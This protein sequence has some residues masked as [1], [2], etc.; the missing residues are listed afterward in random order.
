MPANF[1]SEQIPMLVPRAGSLVVSRDDEAKTVNIAIQVGRHIDAIKLD[2]AGWR[3]LSSALGI[4][5]ARE[6]VP[7]GRTCLKCERGEK[8][9]KHWAAAN[10]CMACMPPSARPGG[11]R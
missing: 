1:V 3:A 4:P 8:A 2:A 11:G 10:M 5:P 7:A 9:V 6:F